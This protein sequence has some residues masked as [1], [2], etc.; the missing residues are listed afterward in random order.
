MD[1]LQDPVTWYGIKYPGTQI[2]E[3]DFQ[4]KGK[5]SWTGKGSFVLEVP[6]CYLRPSVI[7]SIPC[8][9]ILQR[10]NC[11]PILGYPNS[12]LRLTSLLVTQ[13][14][15]QVV[16][17]S[18][19]H[20]GYQS[21]SE[22]WE[23]CILQFRQQLHLTRFKIYKLFCSFISIKSTT[24]QPSWTVGLAWLTP[25]DLLEICCIQ[26]SKFGSKIKSVLLIS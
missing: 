22:Y 4:N 9:W 2:A 24:S 12:T 20:T 16:S 6:L 26:Q 18:S 15:T 13:L 1:P 14:D 8:D 23:R 17:L 5:S 11:T 7:Y 3:W 25:N 21:Y 10:A 19:I